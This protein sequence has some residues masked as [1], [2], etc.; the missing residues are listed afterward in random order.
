LSLLVV[1][2]FSYSL[3]IFL[4]LERFEGIANCSGE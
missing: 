2:H 3:L 4:K 1:T